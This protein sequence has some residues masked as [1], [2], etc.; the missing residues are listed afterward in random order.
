MKQYAIIWDMDG[1][2]VDSYPC[3]VPAVK[4]FCS[5]LGVNYSEDY[6]RKYA[7]RYSVGQLLSELAPLLG[8]DPALLK[9][10]YEIRNDIRIDGIKPMPFAKDLLAFLKEE[11]HLCFVY[12]HRAASC[13]TI[14]ERLDM[15]GFFTE[16]VTSLD[17]FPKKPAPDGILYLLEKY[18]LDPETSFYIGD[19]SLDVASGNSA[20]I[21]S[22]LYIPE[23]SPV[24]SDGTES[25]V[26]HDL[27]EIT[28]IIAADKA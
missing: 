1:T 10:Q 24:E 9:E 22:I 25:Y 15:T 11:G 17:G 5:E 28:E 3:I 14:L 27:K 20:G 21:K 19:R 23:G 18:K 2:L 13:H 4:E 16:V 12:T 8:K 7:M 6:I 26:I